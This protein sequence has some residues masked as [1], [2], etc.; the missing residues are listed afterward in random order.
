M[1]TF[2]NIAA[3][4]F[5]VP[6]SANK[7]DMLS[8]VVGE[9]F[10]IHAIVFKE[11]KKD[12]EN[13]TISITLRP[14]TDYK[15][16]TLKH[17]LNR[18]ATAEAACIGANKVVSAFLED[19]VTLNPLKVTKDTEFVV[20]DG[21]G[22]PFRFIAIDNNDYKA[23]RKALKNGK[24]VE[25]AA[26]I[27]FANS[28][29]TPLADHVAKILD[30]G[31]SVDVAREKAV[32]ERL[33]GGKVSRTTTTDTTTT[34]EHKPSDAAKYIVYASKVQDVKN[35]WL[36]LHKVE[37]RKGVKKEIKDKLIANAT[38]FLTNRMFAAL[39]YEIA[40]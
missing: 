25:Y 39:D 21:K 1:K 18:I 3:T 8:K 30:K 5:S 16:L 19:N 33:Y 7:S 14:I 10:A 24:S 38:D 34:E 15:K 40:M 11:T 17:L 2:F 20:T 29:L 26:G 9:P 22:I 13:G 4:K 28:V 23:L 35:A 12:I 31:K 32:L 37:N 36:A 6:T 27:A